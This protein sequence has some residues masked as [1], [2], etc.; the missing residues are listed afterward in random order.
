MRRSSTESMGTPQVSL[1]CVSHACRR[2]TRAE[3]F[4]LSRS[5]N[6]LNR[7]TPFTSLPI[8]ASVDI[9]GSTG[10]RWYRTREVVPTHSECLQ[11]CA[12]GWCRGQNHRG[13]TE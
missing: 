7:G 13:G 2:N 12:R 8:S 5:Q 9:I 6:V 3:S 11:T 1:S 10:F 4:V